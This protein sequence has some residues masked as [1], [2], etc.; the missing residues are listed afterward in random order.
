MKIGFININ[1]VLF[2]FT[3]LPINKQFR[4]I[5]PGIQTTLA[6]FQVF[7]PTTLQEF[8]DVRSLIREPY[9]MKQF[10]LMIT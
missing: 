10:K 8:H 6:I 3:N 7:I 2:C 9:N 4:W 5:K 1:Y